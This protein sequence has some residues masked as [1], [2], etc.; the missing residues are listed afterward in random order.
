M[1][2]V[3]CRKIPY[4][5]F[6]KRISKTIRLYKKH[7]LDLISFL[8]THNM[9]FRKAVYCALTAFAKGDVFVIKIPPRVESP[10]PLRK[11]YDF[12]LL[13]NPE[14]DRAVIDMLDG[15]EDGY[16]NNFIKNILRMYL[17]TP[18]TSEF[19]KDPAKIDEFETRFN[20][21][22]KG[23]RV[24]DAARVKKMRGREDR[25]GDI[26]S[27]APREKRKQEPEN[28]AFKQKNAAQT[29][30]LPKAVDTPIPR[31]DTHPAE[32]YISAGNQVESA[33]PVPLDADGKILEEQ[34]TPPGNAAESM[35]VD[36]VDSPVECPLDATDDLTELFSTLILG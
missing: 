31:V 26:F 6:M 20:M 4:R 25:L 36:T 21:F 33:P 1:A 34:K 35:A 10:K 8:D 13:L 3:Y 16:K 17:C 22:K 12:R 24:A 32:T 7:D 28:A 19:L 9:N 5:L 30:R 23:R 14:T 2:A 27:A 18:V 11:K 29:V 15:I